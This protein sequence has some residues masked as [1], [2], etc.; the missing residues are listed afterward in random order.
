MVFDAGQNF[1]ANFAYLAASGLG[2]VGSVP[3][4]DHPDLL[5]LPASARRPVDTD[6]FAGLTALTTRATIYGVDRRV[7]LTHS[8]TLHERQDRGFDQTL[9]KAG[10]RLDE[11]AAT[12]ARGKSAASASRSRPRSPASATTPG[13]GESS[14]GS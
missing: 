9:N 10:A 6:R 3:P 12:L 7:V 8:A 4:S 14:S 2:Y 1:T 5:G 11:L 13:P